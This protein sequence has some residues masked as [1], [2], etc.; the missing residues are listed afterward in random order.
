MF[1]ARYG[2]GVYIKISLAFVLKSRLVRVRIVVKPDSQFKYNVILRRV[3]A[4]I[5]VEKQ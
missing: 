1:T 2:L 3:L 5:V 4:T